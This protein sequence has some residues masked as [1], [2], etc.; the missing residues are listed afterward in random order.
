M[1]PLTCPHCGSPL[2]IPESGT[3]PLRCPSCGARLDPV[4]EGL[5]VR[6][7]LVR[8]EED[9]SA[10]RAVDRDRIAPLLGRHEPDSYTTTRASAGT[11]ADETTKALP[12]S[13]VWRTAPSVDTPATPG[14]A[15]PSDAHE[16]THEMTQDLPRSALPPE[17]ST[18]RR[19][20]GALRSLS[21]ALIAL[22]LLAVVAV[23][24]LAANGVFGGP[25]STGATQ[26]T[27]TAA[28]TGSPTAAPDLAPFVVAQLYQVGR[29][30]DW[31]IQQKNAPPKTYFALLTAPTGGPTV[32]IEAQ[33]AADA[34]ALATLDQQFLRALAQDGTTPKLAATPT[35]VSVGGQEWTQLTADMTLRVANGQSSQ[36]YAH[37]V[38][39][40]TQRGA[41]VYTIV[42]LAPAPDT[43]STA[44]AFATA[45]QRYF[46]PMLASFTFLS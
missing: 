20:P 3:T 23:A 27:A 24:A 12:I 35:S 13:A 39:L 45:D 29:P 36:Q 4:G 43:A 2:I 22:T 46:Q 9:D 32:N 38:A 28:S 17:S 8:D 41:Y 34:P 40:S 26:P 6:E 18:E 14:A 30:R 5:P 7:A 10:T 37:V 21:I 33:Q 16:T 25:S 42:Y 11:S 19:A 15:S 44:A 31:L 1:P